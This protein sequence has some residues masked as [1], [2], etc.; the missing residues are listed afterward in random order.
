MIALVVED[1]A[2]IRAIVARHLEGL[3]Y[4]VLEA[5][6]LGDAVPLLSD[7]LDLVVLDLR[8][9]DGRGG[10]LLK[11]LAETRNDVPVIVLTAYPADHERLDGIAPLVQL[12]EKPFQWKT[13]YEAVGRA[14]V[15]RDSVRRL[16]AAT[17]RLDR[18]IEKGETA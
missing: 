14:Q 18:V 17:R 1:H 12:L 7:A 5:G 8:L 6:T 10:T 13:F 2:H 16:K 4:S 11:Q 9:P 3:G 15:A